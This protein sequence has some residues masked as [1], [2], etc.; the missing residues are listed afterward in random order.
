MGS[1]T[2]SPHSQC[3]FSV[4]VVQAASST[5]SGRG[6]EAASFLHLLLCSIHSLFS[7]ESGPAAISPTWPEREWG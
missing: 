6:G 5:S 3:L 7:P 4:K 1:Q 2:L